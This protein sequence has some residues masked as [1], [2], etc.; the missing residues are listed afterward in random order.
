MLL[1]NYINAQVLQGNPSTYS[2]NPLKAITDHPE[3]AGSD[4]LL[5][6]VIQ[7]CCNEIKYITLCYIV[8]Y[9]NVKLIIIRVLA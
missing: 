9:N 8:Q 3:N 7:V 2:A 6:S 1:L 4:T 5:V